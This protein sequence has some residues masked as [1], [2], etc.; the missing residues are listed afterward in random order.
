MKAKKFG[1]E[2]INLIEKHVIDNDI[3]KN[4]DLV[5]K[6]SGVNS[7]I[8]LFF[9]QSVDKKLSIDEMAEAKRVEFDQVVKDLETIIYSGTKLDLKYIIDDL[10]DDDC[11]KELIE[12]FNNLEDDNINEIINEFEDEYEEDDLKIFR[13][14]HY[15]KTA[16]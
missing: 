16:F 5:I 11:Q 15:C 12:Y 6:S 2:F 4:F 1:I 8:K 3:T 7:S 13:L 9:I 14:Y 10:F